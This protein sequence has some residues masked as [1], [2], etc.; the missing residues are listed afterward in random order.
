MNDGG[1]RA[2]VA[3]CGDPDGA[4]GRPWGR[5]LHSGDVR[6]DA[7]GL[8]VG[9][10]GRNHERPS[11]REDGGAC[12]LYSSNDDVHAGEMHAI[13]AFD[14][15]ADDCSGGNGLVSCRGLAGNC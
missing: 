5:A 13:W 3:G 8:T 6:L 15:R 1:V 9:C 14:G 7:M 4:R 2:A 11:Y 12:S 10:P